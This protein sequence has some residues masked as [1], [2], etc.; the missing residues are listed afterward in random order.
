MEVHMSKQLPDRPNL[1]H[2]RKQAKDLLSAYRKNDPDAIQRIKSLPS[3]SS[4]SD[5]DFGT[6]RVA[7]HDTQSVVAREYGFDSWT[8]LVV[9]VEEIRAQEGITPEIIDKFM[10]L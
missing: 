9:R 6:Q 8:K 2:L 10:R 4:L 7:L 5:K 3:L 1:D